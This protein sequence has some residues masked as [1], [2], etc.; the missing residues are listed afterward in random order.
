MRSEHLSAYEAQIEELFKRVRI[1][2]E[3][4]EQLS[5]VAKQ[6]R[7]DVEA[8]VRLAVSLG[9]QA[10]RNHYSWTEHELRKYSEHVN[11]AFQSQCQRTQTLVSRL[12]AS[13]ESHEAILE[14]QHVKFGAFVHKRQDDLENHCSFI[15][16]R[17]QSITTG[18]QQCSNEPHTILPRGSVSCTEGTKEQEH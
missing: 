4:S 2:R 14:Q 16:G 1:S 15:S 18:L 9:E 7:E 10:W 13:V 8:E 5:T 17:S 6:L 11:A 12:M 3:T